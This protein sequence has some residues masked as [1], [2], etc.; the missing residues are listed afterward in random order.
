[1]YGKRVR[2]EESSSSSSSSSYS[3]S[4]SSSSLADILLNTASSYVERAITQN[5]DLPIIS[6]KTLQLIGDLDKAVQGLSSRYTIL[7]PV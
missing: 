4:S 1:M 3:S 7:N 2:T 5:K 6:S